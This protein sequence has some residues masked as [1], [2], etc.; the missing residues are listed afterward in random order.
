MI[1]AFTV[2]PCCLCIVRYPMEERVSICSFFPRIKSKKRYIAEGS[3]KCQSYW[4]QIF[5]YAQENVIRRVGVFF[6]SKRE[7]VQPICL[8][9][10]LSSSYFRINITNSSRAIASVYIL[11]HGS[12]LIFLSYHMFSFRKGNPNCRCF[13]KLI[14]ET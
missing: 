14:T 12:L 6:L 5:H 4:G 7:K 10:Y 13:S 8:S 9:E 1:V 11:Y 3:E 2:T